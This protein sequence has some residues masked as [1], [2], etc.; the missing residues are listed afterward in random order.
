MSAGQTEAAVVHPW[1]LLEPRAPAAKAETTAW[2]ATTI[3]VIAVAT[4][5]SFTTA[6]YRAVTHSS[7]A[8]VLRA[9]SAE[10]HQAPAVIQ[11]TP[12]MKPKT[13]RR[14]RFHAVHRQAHLFVHA[15]RA[16]PPISV[17]L[18]AME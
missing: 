8:V 6:A 17:P 5:N 3:A 14:A 11:S 13:G 10:A 2:A 12:V 1:A 16:A 18:G 15:R 4:G 7:L 9:A